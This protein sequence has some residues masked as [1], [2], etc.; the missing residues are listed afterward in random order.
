MTDDIP[1]D[2][3]DFSFEFAP[4]AFDN[5]E[6]TQAE[7]DEMIEEISEAVQAAIA[8]G[9]LLEQSQA[10]DMNQLEEDDPEMFKKMM[11]VTASLEDENKRK[12]N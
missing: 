4:G 6:G 2:I 1:D 7:L 12:L 10:I 3:S 8:D 11:D 9:S 5:F